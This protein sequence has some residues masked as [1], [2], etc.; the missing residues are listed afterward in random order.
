MIVRV[1]NYPEYMTERC[2]VQ[3]EHLIRERHKQDITELLGFG[4][5]VGPV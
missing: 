4:G 3:H 5:I 1:S 2:I